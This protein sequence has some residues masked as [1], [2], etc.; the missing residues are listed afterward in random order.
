MSEARVSVSNNEITMNN[1]PLLPMQEVI[2]LT[3]TSRNLIKIYTVEVPSDGLVI[4]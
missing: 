4:A 1:L 2:L 3:A